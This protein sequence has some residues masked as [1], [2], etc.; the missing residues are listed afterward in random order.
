MIY[1]TCNS[2]FF[3]TFAWFKIGNTAVAVSSDKDETSLTVIENPYETGKITLSAVVSTA[4]ISNLVPSDTSGDVYYDRGDGTLVK[5]T[6]ASQGTATWAEVTVKIKA[7]LTESTD[8]I[9]TL[10]KAY[11]A[12]SAADLAKTYYV[13]VDATGDYVKINTAKWGAG[14][15]VDSSSSAK[16]LNQ[17][18]LS[19]STAGT[20]FT[21]AAAVLTFYVGIN[22]GTSASNN[23]YDDESSDT[24]YKLESYVLATA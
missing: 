20:E 15:S 6:T 5:D 21:T 17:L 4:S 18:G 7:E 9:D 19:D 3:S 22:G 24:G 8:E 2:H 1:S 10:G 14:T 16:T 11:A 13:K 12:L 23:G